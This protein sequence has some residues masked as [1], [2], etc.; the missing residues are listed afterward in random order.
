[1]AAFFLLMLKMALGVHFYLTEGTQKCFILDLPQSTVVLGNYNL[2]DVPPPDRPEQGVNLIVYDEK[3]AQ[4]L[5][6]LVKGAGKFSF[7]SQNFGKHRVCAA[8][9]STSWFGT[10]RKLRFELKMDNTKEEISHEH[11]ASK[12]QLGHL[13]EIVNNLNERLTEVIKQQEYSREKEAMFKDESEDINSK[14]MLFTIIQTLVILVS[15]L[16]QIWSLR[17]FFISR[18]LI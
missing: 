11:L 4:V 17:R 16:W 13:E 7:T 1:M 2:L 8:A 6:R 12:E 18:K 5:T 3:G 9:T 10:P 14:I 15:G